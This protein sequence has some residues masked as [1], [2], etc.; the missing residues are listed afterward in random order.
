[1]KTYSI[2]FLMEPKGWDDDEYN[3]YAG[4]YYATVEA[5]KTEDVKAAIHN[6]YYDMD[7]TFVKVEEV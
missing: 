2:T 3:P 4:R 7:I 5:A 6:E 1:M